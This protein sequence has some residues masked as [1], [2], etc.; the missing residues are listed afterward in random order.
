MRLAVA[1]ELGV[2]L[3]AC[4]PWRMPSASDRCPDLP[5][6]RSPHQGKGHGANPLNRG[7][8]REVE[9]GRYPSGFPELPVTMPTKLAEKSGDSMPRAGNAGYS[10]CRHDDSYRTGPGFAP[11][12]ERC[13]S[14]EHTTIVR[15]STPGLLNGPWPAGVV[16]QPYRDPTARKGDDFTSSLPRITAAAAAWPRDRGTRP[17]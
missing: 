4:P 6:C 10:G 8:T 13:L 3:Q 14:R 7:Q 16:P 11:A 12:R 9:A 2:S 15:F 5:A 1:G 17:A